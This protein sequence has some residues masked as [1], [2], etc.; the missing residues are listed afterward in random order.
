MPVSIITLSLLSVTPMEL[1]MKKTLPILM[2]LMLF[3]G[4]VAAISSGSSMQGD[5]EKYDYET[6]RVA[7]LYSGS[8]YD[9]DSYPLAASFKRKNGEVTPMIPVF[10]GDPSIEGRNIFSM[11]LAAK[12]LNM[13]VAISC[14]RRM[15]D[16]ISL[17][18]E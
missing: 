1:K 10:R 4:G 13:P 17:I 6:M 5:C 15:I 2:A 3:S 14:H 18:A 7:R 12:T 8:S 11:L 16:T 9:G